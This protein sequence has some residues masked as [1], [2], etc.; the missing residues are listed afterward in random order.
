M[1]ICE[2]NYTPTD[3][4]TVTHLHHLP[5]K[6]SSRSKLVSPTLPF[7]VPLLREGHDRSMVQR[8]MPA[9]LPLPMDRA[10]PPAATPLTPITWTS[11][12]LSPA[13]ENDLDPESC[14]LPRLLALHHTSIQ[15]L[16]RS[17]LDTPADNLCDTKHSLECILPRRRTRFRGTMSQQVDT[18]RMRRDRMD[19]SRCLGLQR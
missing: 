5:E 13:T 7:P 3:Q 6:I 16:D 11:T 8:P 19:Q 9:G 18:T 15:T 10:L 2:D 1:P 4:I 12:P 14:R 17:T